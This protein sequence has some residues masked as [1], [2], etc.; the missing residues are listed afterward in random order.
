MA[1]LKPLPPSLA[2]KPGVAF[3]DPPA[4]LILDVSRHI[5]EVLATLPADTQG[6]IVAVGTDRGINVAVVHKV[7]DRFAVSAWIG[8]DWGSKVT[9]GAMVR[10]TW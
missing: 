2:S 5:N 10:A 4:K 9:G 3:T 7:N 1:D 8:K 6:A